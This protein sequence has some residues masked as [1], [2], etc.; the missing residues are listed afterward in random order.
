[1]AAVLAVVILVVAVLPAEYGIDPLG[2][3]RVL[4][5]T[6]MSALPADEEPPVVAEGAPLAPVQEGQVAVYPAE[7]KVDS[8]VFEIGPYEYLE[9]KYHLEKG[10]TMLFSWNATH[11]VRADFHGDAD[12]AK[13][14]DE[15]TSYDDRR[16]RRRAGSFAAPFTGIHGWYWE[17][18]GGEPVT[19]NVITSGFY[20]FAREFRMDKSQRTHQM[21]RLD[22][23]VPQTGSAK[24]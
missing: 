24:E 6:A 13:P 2:A 21:Q 3:G 23:A 15:P 17:N 18:L 12:G 16:G 22:I 11:D 4:G 20:T 8:R 10:A 1:M 19:V 9:F 14:T 5:L 7:F